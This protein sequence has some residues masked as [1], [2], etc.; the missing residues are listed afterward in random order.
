MEVFRKEGVNLDYVKT[1][2]ESGSNFSVVVNVG[3][4]RTILVY[5]EKRE[6]KLPE[7]AET[8]WL[9]FTSLGKGHDL[10]HRQIPEFIKKSGAKLAFQPGS[11]QLREGK[12][13]L[14]E[15]LE[16]TEVILL[17]KEE[18]A[19]LLGSKGEMKELLKNLA[20]LGPKI[21]VITDGV[22]GS[23]S[24]DGKT[25]RLAGI[26]P[27]SETVER[28]GAGDAYSTAFVAGLISGEEVGQAM[29]WGSAN[30][31]S[32]VEHIGA[33]EGLLTKEGMKK[34]LDGCPECKWEEE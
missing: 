20:S 23:W 16:V 22:N 17:N 27:E 32:V 10:L 7:L 31:S 24:F 25:V 3:A 15:I 1:Q 30:A 19:G 9:Y 14:R 13:G 5:H 2:K 12:E 26:F 6:Y 4:E 28:T 33:R 34:R 29:R 8:K 21:V 11:H 18:A